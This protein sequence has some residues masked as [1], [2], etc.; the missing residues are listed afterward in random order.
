MYRGTTPTLT[1]TL[2]FPCDQ[3]NFVSIAF[4]QKKTPYD[5]DATLVMEKLLTDCRADG[6]TLS[7]TLSESDTLALDCHFPVEIQLRVK[8]NGASMASDIITEDVQRI[9]KDGCLP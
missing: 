6:K 5:K 2:P 1:F 3:L 9:L 8:C 7:L 4:A